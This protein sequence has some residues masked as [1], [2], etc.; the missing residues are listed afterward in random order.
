[1]EG[2]VAKQYNIPW[3]SITKENVDALLTE[4]E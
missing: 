1:M 3:S 2:S 4:R